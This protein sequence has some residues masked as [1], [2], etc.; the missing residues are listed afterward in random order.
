MGVFDTP[1]VKKGGPPPM[2]AQRA[3]H[4]VKLPRSPEVIQMQSDGQGVLFRLKGIKM[5]PP[6]TFLSSSWGH[7]A[8]ALFNEVSFLHG[9]MLSFVVVN[10]C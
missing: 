5:T 3:G 9:K 7:K 1:D 2:C 6:S 8:N 4:E 10:K